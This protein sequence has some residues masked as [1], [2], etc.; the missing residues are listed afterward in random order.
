M[1]SADQTSQ[2]IR[3]FNLISYIKDIII[4]LRPKLKN[5]QYV[6]D[7]SCPDNFELE[8]NP[9][10]IAQIITNLIMNSLIH[11]FN[12]GD[13]G[14]IAIS[15]KQVDDVIVLKYSDNGK[16]VLPEHLNKIFDPFFT[17]KRGAGGTGLGLNIVYN[18]V[19]KALKGT[20]RCESSPGLGTTFIMEL[21]INLNKEITARPYKPKELRDQA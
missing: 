2:E 1:V 17:T 19:N 18:I 6:I 13:N 16:G 8:T 12:E 20:I 10:A 9:G 3:K 21:P 11:G 4:S 7:L 5:T 15:C 14:Q